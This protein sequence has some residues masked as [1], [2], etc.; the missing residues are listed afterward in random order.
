MYPAMIDLMITK[1]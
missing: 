1:D